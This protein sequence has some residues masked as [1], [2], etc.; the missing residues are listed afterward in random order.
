MVDVIYQWTLAKLNDTP[1]ATWLMANIKK[2][3][4]KI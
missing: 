1:T 3:E 2:G 4:F